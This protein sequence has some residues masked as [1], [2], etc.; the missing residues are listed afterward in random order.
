MKKSKSTIRKQSLIAILILAVMLTFSI[1]MSVFA[2]VD[3]VHGTVNAI[4]LVKSQDTNGNVRIFNIFGNDLNSKN[5]EII[6]K[7]ASTKVVESDIKVQFT[8]NNSGVQAAITFPS[9]TEDVT[10]Q[11]SAKSTGE[12]K[13]VECN[14]D[15]TIKGNPNAAD[16]NK[17]VI[18]SVTASPEH[19]SA[20]GGTVHLN[21]TG[22]D[23]NDADLQIT[24]LSYYEGQESSSGYVQQLT[25]LSITA[26]GADVTIPENTKSSV[27][28]HKFTVSVQGKEK[29]AKTVI[30][31][32]AA[33]SAKIPNTELAIN[34][35][36]ITGTDGKMDTVAVSFENEIPKQ[37]DDFLKHVYIAN[38]V[39]GDQ[40]VYRLTDNDSYE[41]QGN[42]L[43]LHLV[44]SFDKASATTKIYFE[45]GAFTKDNKVNSS[46]S[47]TLASGAD[48]SAIQFDHDTLNYK[49]GL[50]TA[51]LKGN[52]LDKAKKI[53]GRVFVGEDTKPSA[54]IQVQVDQTG[55]EP[56]L[57][58]TVPENKTDTT[59]S[60]LLDI[61]IDGTPVYANRAVVSV[62]P[63]GV[64]EGTQTLGDV[65]ISGNNNETD[66]SKDK[67]N[68]VFTKTITGMETSVKINLTLKGTGLDSAKT[69]VRAFDENGVLWRVN[70][71]S[72]CEG[73]IRFHAIIGEHHNGVK[74]DGTVQTI[75]LLPPSKLGTSHTYRF[76]IALD[77]VHFQRV[78][79]VKLIV[80]N[81]GIVE[82]DG[83]TPSDKAEFSNSIF[84]VQYQDENGEE[85]AKENEYAGYGVSELC[86]YDVKAKE[87]SG[88]TKVSGP[89]EKFLNEKFVKDISTVKDGNRVLIYKYKKNSAVVPST[90]SVNPT[91]STPSDQKEVVIKQAVL[92]KTT[93][94]YTGKSIADTII[95]LDKNNNIVD[96][97]NY[98]ITGVSTKVG[99][100]TITVTGKDGVT[101]SVQLEYTVLPAKVLGLN[102]KSGKKLIKVSWKKHK[103]QTT[104][105]QIQ[106]GTSKNMKKGKVKTIKNPAAVKQTIKKL[107]SKRTYYV[108]IRAF[109]RMNNGKNIKTTY[110]S[111][112]SSVKKAA[113]R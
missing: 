59:Q 74:G 6:A 72:Q 27:I 5:V 107:A 10:Y 112:W 21:L 11:I 58:F 41:I 39:Q 35:A 12:N 98:D 48:V 67:I 32:Q 68:K 24:S 54:V 104:G 76:E 14:S 99:T 101:G 37:A 75:E 84:K 50:V 87:I 23:L 100:H 93:L 69:T 47:W 51:R 26:A 106:Y 73:T 63:K 105:F 45:E 65:T 28:E 88:Y 25:G 64:E 43:V 56:I 2:D 97:K 15:V 61:S 36:V 113:V 31:T 108:R 30:V 9:R 18:Q 53:T 8:E 49:G 46:F 85:I 52:N 7:D 83:F 94:H 89:T 29:D 22:T 17:G 86:N 78:P 40:D 16:A 109:K 71:D 102:V 20:K 111:D 3:E 19:I 62:L 79:D 44:K 95:V 70:H 66:P 91:P 92:K 103:A 96:H 80:N 1:P 33:A 34:N 77:G 38:G 60:Y 42:N 4:T 13:Y 110:Y 81:T 57:T 55:A 90:P 82:D